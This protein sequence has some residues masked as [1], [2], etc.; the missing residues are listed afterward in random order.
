[1]RPR[2]ALR[3]RPR[4]PGR[5][6]R[7][8]SPSSRS[9][10]PRA[11]STRSSGRERRAW[12]SAPPPARSGAQ[13]GLILP[14]LLVPTALMGGTLPVLVRLTGEGTERLGVRAATLYAANTF[15]AVAGG[16]AAGGPPP[17][18]PG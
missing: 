14:I 11:S 6:P 17:P 9:R 4:P 15:G 2:A 8:C 3:P 13:F 5:R 10:G 18:A 12:A 16:G 7:S 1:M